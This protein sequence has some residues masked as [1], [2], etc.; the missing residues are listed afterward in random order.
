MA[1]S[2]ELE[3]GAIC[4]KVANKVA[5]DERARDAYTDWQHVVRQQLAA[6]AGRTHEPFALLVDASML[7]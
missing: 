6:A 4:N 7:V 3:L 5:R 2:F 1:A